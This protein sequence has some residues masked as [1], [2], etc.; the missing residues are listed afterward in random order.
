MTGSRHPLA[1]LSEAEI[2]LSANLARGCHDVGAKLRFKGIMLHEPSRKE[3]QQYRSKAD[4][5]NYSPPRKAWVNYYIAGTASFF[6]SIVDLTAESVERQNEVPAQFHG[7]IDED[8]I[9]TVEKVALED[10][11]TKAEIEKLQ[12]PEG[13]VVVCDPWIW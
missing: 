8:E 11:R 4:K 1:S 13:A 3:M 2:I 10:A 5:G 6:E 9:I 7:P 12:L